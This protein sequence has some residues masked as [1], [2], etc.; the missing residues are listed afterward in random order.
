[1]S[2]LVD[3]DDVKD[4]S[5]EQSSLCDSETSRTPLSYIRCGNKVLHAESIV[6]EALSYRGL[7]P[8]DEHGVARLYLLCDVGCDRDALNVN[9]DVVGEILRHP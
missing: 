2:E 1:M 7:E 8:S 5:I 3:S 9:V 4:T 6:D